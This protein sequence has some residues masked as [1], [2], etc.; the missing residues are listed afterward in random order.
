MKHICIYIL[1]ISSI[2][3]AQSDTKL[4]DYFS[5]SSKKIL[6]NNSNQ[7][8]LGSAALAALVATTIDQNVKAY[9]QDK[10]LLPE[11]VSHFGDMYG[12]YWAHW[13][14]WSSIVG[15]SMAKKENNYF[16]EKLEFSTLATISR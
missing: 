9:A 5:E 8:I 16:S 11:K 13:I 1:I 3:D 10:G 2:L 15:T 12:G 4:T 7:F 6:S 14:I